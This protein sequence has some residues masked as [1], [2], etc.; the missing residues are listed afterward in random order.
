MGEGSDD[1]LVMKYVFELEFLVFAV[2]EPFLG[3]LIASDIEFPSDFGDLVKVLGGVD[4]DSEG[5]I[6]HPVYRGI[7]AQSTPALQAS[8]S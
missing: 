2:F 4:I 1:F 5:V 6:V 8:P 3:W 7:K